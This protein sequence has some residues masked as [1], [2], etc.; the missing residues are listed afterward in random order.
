MQRRRLDIV[1]ALAAT[2]AGILAAC[3]GAS[4]DEEALAPEPG[5]T[6]STQET[7]APLAGPSRPPTA[8]RR[9]DGSRRERDP[10]DPASRDRAYTMPDG[11]VVIPPPPVASEERQAGR[12]CGEREGNPVPPNPGLSA[13]LAGDRAVAI[14][15]E[16]AD[17]RRHCRAVRAELAVDVAG[18]GYAG[19][20][21]MVRIGD[22]GRSVHRVTLP[23]WFR[24]TPDI[25]RASVSTVTR[26]VSE[27]VS[28]RIR[29]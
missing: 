3:G 12:R 28:V 1:C 15:V 26:R 11:T 25:A 19:Y 5:T 20:S 17:V 4:T 6:Q 27:T 8:P 7:T 22:P 18:D 16:T 23:A 14:T 24:G 2:A 29:R 9:P 13:R 21:T 10:A